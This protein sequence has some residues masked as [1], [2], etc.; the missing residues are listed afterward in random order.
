MVDAIQ[1]LLALR[2]DSYSTSPGMDP[3]VP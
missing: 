1:I 3:Q 2:I